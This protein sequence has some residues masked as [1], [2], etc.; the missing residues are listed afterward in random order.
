MADFCTAYTVRA[1]YCATAATITVEAH[2]AVARASILVTHNR[3]IVHMRDLTASDMAGDWRHDPVGR[4]QAFLSR[5]MGERG[6]FLEWLDWAA[7]HGLL[8]AESA[9]VT[10]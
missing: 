9:E 10:P 6:S 4:A 5:D 8:S 3:R 2:G 1:Q 7:R